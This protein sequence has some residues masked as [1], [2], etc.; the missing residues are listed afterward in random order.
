MYKNLSIFGLKTR[1]PIDDGRRFVRSGMA[2]MAQWQ[3]WHICSA[4]KF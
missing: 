1:F 2:Q 4:G 3:Q